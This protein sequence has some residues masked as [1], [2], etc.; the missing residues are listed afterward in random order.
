[1]FLLGTRKPPTRRAFNSG[2]AES[3]SPQPAVVVSTPEPV[4]APAPGMPVL[5]YCYLD[6]YYFTLS[7]LLLLQIL[8]TV[9]IIVVI[10]NIS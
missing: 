4:A 3:L 10:T 5:I 1:M 9:I 6:D 7:L 8:I 2:S